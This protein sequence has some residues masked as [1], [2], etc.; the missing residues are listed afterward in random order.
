MNC[1]PAPEEGLLFGPWCLLFGLCLKFG[2]LNLFRISCFV[3]SAFEKQNL[4][5]FRI[6]TP[7]SP[8]RGYLRLPGGAVSSAVAARRLLGES[9]SALRDIVGACE[10][11]G[12][13][14]RTGGV[15]IV[16][17]DGSRGAGENRLEL[18]ADRLKL[19][20]AELGAAVCGANVLGVYDLDGVA[21]GADSLG[22][23]VRGVNVLGVYDLDG[24]AL[25]A[26]SLGA[27]VCGANVLGVYDLDGVAL[28]ADSL[29]VNVRG[30]NV[31]G[32]YVLDGVAL[33]AGSLGAAVR[34]ANVLGVYDLDGVALGADSLGAAVR[35]VNVLSVYDRDGVALGAGS[36][37]AA[38]RGVNV[39]G[40]YDG[41]VVALGAAVESCGQ[42]ERENL[43]SRGGAMEVVRGVGV[44]VTL[45]V[46]EMVGVVTVRGVK[47]CG[48]RLL[49][50]RVRG[51][52]V[53]E[54]LGQAGSGG[55]T[56]GWNVLCC[57][58]GPA[59]AGAE[60][61]AAGVALSRLSRLF[62]ISCRRAVTAA[63]MS[64]ADDCRDTSPAPNPWFV[65]GPAE[66]VPAGEVAPNA[67]LT[68]PADGL[69]AVP[70]G[71]GLRRPSTSMYASRRCW[72]CTW[73]VAPVMPLGEVLN[74]LPARPTAGAARADI[75]PFVSVRPGLGKAV[76]RVAPAPA[77]GVC[78]R[79]LRST[80][81]CCPSRE[82]SVDRLKLLPLRAAAIWCDTLG[83]HGLTGMPDVNDRSDGAPPCAKNRESECLGKSRS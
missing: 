16:G 42:V 6:V 8:V 12:P 27:A 78:A 23:A 72:S 15:L 13:Y 33:G 41:G 50:V 29:G 26:G 3:F 60:P 52:A 31:L 4:H 71:P 45:G 81:P 75:P 80:G 82:R 11:A 1:G 28:G 32:V 18:G 59:G 22:A 57:R 64:G 56:C 77:A 67:G 43:I 36:L 34:G 7:A 14:V 70:P 2:A 21:L 76:A 37:G 17:P 30:V 48:V 38:V 65:R 74:V 63:S 66:A 55:A 68:T 20:S 83:R 69:S 47:L 73:A 53:T 61:E 51:P 24:V 62:R 5:Q 44:S 79:R 9:D 10:G 39:L 49:G 19:G 35:G 58:V 54:R 46:S 25:G 40:L